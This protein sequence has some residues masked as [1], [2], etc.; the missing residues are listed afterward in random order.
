MLFRFTDFDTQATV[1]HAS[2]RLF[3]LCKAVTGRVGEEAET[4]VE[5]WRQNHQ[6][7]LIWKALAERYSIEQVCV[8]FAFLFGTKR[9]YTFSSTVSLGAHSHRDARLILLLHGIRTSTGV[10][11]HVRS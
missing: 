9:R 11:L 6:D 2:K 8:R 3:A 10:E 1:K 4:Q 7:N 5:E